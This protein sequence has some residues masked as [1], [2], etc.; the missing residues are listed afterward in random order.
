M[1]AAAIYIRRSRGGLVV[2]AIGRTDRGQSYIKGSRNLK[3]KSMGDKD[4]K[5]Q[6]KTAVDELLGSDA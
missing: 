3:V 5:G 2:A 4:F 1:Q 6:M